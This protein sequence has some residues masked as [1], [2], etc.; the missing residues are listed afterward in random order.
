[1]P[2]LSPTAPAACSKSD[3]LAVVDR[4]TNLRSWT[5]ALVDLIEV[6][7]HAQAEAKIEIADRT[8][9]KAAELLRDLREQMDSRI[10]VI[11]NI[12]R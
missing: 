3:R 10:D 4:Y 6:A 8:L 12:R 1:M 11:G 5:L 9:V 7:G 2:K